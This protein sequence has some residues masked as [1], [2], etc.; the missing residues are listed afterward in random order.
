MKKKTFLVLGS[1]G[2]DGKIFSNLINKKLYKIIG[3]SKKHINSKYDKNY[4]LNFLNKNSDHELRKIL[5]HEKPNYVI[6]FSGLSSGQ[7]ME[8]NSFEKFF[9]V[10]TKPVISIINYCID[11]PKTVLVQASS[12]EIFGDPVETPQSEN[13]IKKPRNYYGITKYLSDQII[14]YNRKKYKLN[15]KSAILYNHESIYRG[16]NFLIP[17]ICNFCSYLAIHPKTERKLKI[18]NIKTKR[19]WMHADNTVEAI[20]KMIFDKR[21]SDYVIGYGKSLSI[22]DILK[23]AFSKINKDYNDFIEV[24]VSLTHADEKNIVEANISKI[25]KELGW[26]PK[27]NISDLVNELILKGIKK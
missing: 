5:Y 6:N 7:S 24:D 3:V 4:S 26:T 15:L 25:S 17:K 8:K 18:G 10:N 1:N 13:T 22:E 27:V 19:D 12:R 14:D 9:K 16:K 11:F 23:I 21:N 20:I 2:Q